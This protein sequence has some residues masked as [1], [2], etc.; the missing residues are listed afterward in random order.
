MFKA[1]LD[2]FFSGPDAVDVTVSGG[3][4]FRALLDSP[5]EPVAQFGISTE[6]QLTAKSSDVASLAEGQTI[7][8]GGV[9]YTVRTLPRKLDDGA[10]SIVQIDKV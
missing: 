8:I 6:Y 5:D 4:S 9:D 1:D 2:V 3:S 10:M 7:T